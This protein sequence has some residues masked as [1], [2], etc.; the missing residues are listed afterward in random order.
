L[1]SGIEEGELKK[2]TQ[3]KGTGA[4]IIAGSAFAGLTHEE[5]VE[6]A[7]RLGQLNWGGAGGLGGEDGAVATAF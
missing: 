5:T 4:R 7:T 2:K 3:R 1:G 6:L